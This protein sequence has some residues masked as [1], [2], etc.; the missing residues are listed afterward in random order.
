MLLTCCVRE[1]KVLQGA[2][3]APRSHLPGPHLKSSLWTICTAPWQQPRQRTSWSVTTVLQRTSENYWCVHGLY[4]GAIYFPLMHVDRYILRCRLLTSL[5]PW[6]S[7]GC[8][9]HPNECGC[10]ASQWSHPHLVKSEDPSVPGKRSTTAKMSSQ[11]GPFQ[12]TT[13]P[14]SRLFN[15]MGRLPNSCAR[16]QRPEDLSQTDHLVPHV[17]PLIP[18]K[19]RGYRC[20]KR[21]WFA[22]FGQSAHPD[23]TVA[24]LL[25]RA[26]EFT[27]PALAL[28]ATGK[29]TDMSS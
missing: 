29:S 18:G 8:P 7:F 11:R 19:G 25:C 5:R 13:A 17:A 16:R 26:G 23:Q 15:L 6:Q 10:N 28:P 12:K 2:A 20:G 4:S 9:T 1:F 24:N 27:I 3:Y 22:S 14:N 21:C